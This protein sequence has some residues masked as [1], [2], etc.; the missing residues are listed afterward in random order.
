VLARLGRGDQPKENIAKNS[1]L[2]PVDSVRARQKQVRD[3]SQ[4]L[5]TALGRTISNG[6]IKLSNE[7][8]RSNVDH[9]RRQ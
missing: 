2:T 8:G 1:G 3:L 4:H 7:L 9:R 6:V 5:S